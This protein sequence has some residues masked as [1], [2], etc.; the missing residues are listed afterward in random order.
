MTVG[1][2]GRKAVVLEKKRGKVY[3]AHPDSLVWEGSQIMVSRVLDGVP[4]PKHVWRVG[5]ED[6]AALP[7]DAACDDPEVP[8]EPSE[9]SEGMYMKY[10]YARPR[11]KYAF[12]GQAFHEKVIGDLRASLLQKK[13]GAVTLVASLFPGLGDDMA[14]ALNMQVLG[15]TVPRTLSAREARLYFVGAE[16]DIEGE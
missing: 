4:F 13:P 1:S 15:S 6:I 14:A 5:A 3:E 7:Q 9:L 8:V 12:R 11:D 16:L 10:G 2:L